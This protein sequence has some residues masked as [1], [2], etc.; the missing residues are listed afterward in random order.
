MTVTEAQVT[1]ANNMN[2]AKQVIHFCL[3]EL[4]T[5][6]FGTQHITYGDG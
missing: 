4:A 5:V 6:N 2:R 3:C 1:V